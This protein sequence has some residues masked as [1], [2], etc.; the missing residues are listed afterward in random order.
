MDKEMTAVDCASIV[1]KCRRCDCECFSQLSQ[2]Q[3][4]YRPDIS[5]RSRVE[6]R[7]V[8]EIKLTTAE[9]FQPIESICRFADCLFRRAGAG[10]QCDNHRVDLI[11]L[12]GRLWYP[13]CLNGSKAT[14]HEIIR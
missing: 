8:F 7:T 3:L 4:D 5:T 12:R 10:F 6:R 2:E 14:F 9:R 1:W 11:Q 13:D